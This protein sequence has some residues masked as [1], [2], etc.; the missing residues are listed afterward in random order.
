MVIL[1]TLVCPL[2][3]SSIIEKRATKGPYSIVLCRLCHLVFVYPIPSEEQMREFYTNSYFSGG[4]N[5][6]IGYRMGFKDY[7]GDW[8]IHMANAKNVMNKVCRF[9]TDKPG[10]LLDVG[11]AHGFLLNY[12]RSHGWRVKGIDLS[13]YAVNFARKE[14]QLDVIEGTVSSLKAHS[15]SFDVC[16]AIDVFNHL[17]NPFSVLEEISRILKPEGLFVLSVINI[18]GVLPFHW[19]PPEHLFYF[20]RRSIKLM[21]RKVGLEVKQISFFW[22]CYSL[23]EFL[24]RLH[25]YI[26]WLWIPEVDSG[27]TRKH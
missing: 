5:V 6:E 21:L 22:Q 9:W 13:T 17:R 19:K 26:K 8:S 14:L 20:S 15:N 18:S 25:T 11:C 16:T 4:T 10:F 23:R 3:G 1:S 2:C 12:A 7:I 27:F 24:L